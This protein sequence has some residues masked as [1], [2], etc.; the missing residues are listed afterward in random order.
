[1]ERGSTRMR[2]MVDTGATVTALS[3]DVAEA[4]GIERDALRPDAMNAV[5]NKITVA[6]IATVTLFLSMREKSIPL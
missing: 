4:A 5:D 1:M 3:G 6:I 2:L